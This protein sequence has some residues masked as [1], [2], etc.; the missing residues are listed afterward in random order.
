[1]NQDGRSTRR[2]LD[3]QVEDLPHARALADDVGELVI[4]LLDVLSKIAVLVHEAAP[5]EGVAYD[6]QHLVVLERL[7]DVVEG[8]GLHRGDSASNGRKRRDDHDSQIFVD[9]LQLVQRGDAVEPRHHDVDDGAIEGQR[10]RQLEPLFPRRGEAH[11]VPLAAQQR[12]EDLAHDLLVVD[13][14]DRAVRGGGHRV[15]QPLAA[16]RA[17]AALGKVSVK[18]VP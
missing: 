16:V 9:A 4:A 18:R 6:H 17:A 5:L 10:A 2:G 3:D 13:D 7:G 1:M 8:T 11:R 15:P 14:E 12:L